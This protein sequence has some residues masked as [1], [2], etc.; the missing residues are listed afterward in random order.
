MIKFCVIN[1]VRNRA[2]I[3]RKLSEH[4][5]KSVCNLYVAVLIITKVSWH[6]NYKHASQ[7]DC[8]NGKSARAS[9]HQYFYLFFCF[10]RYEY[11]VYGQ[12]N[13]SGCLN[14]LETRQNYGVHNN[15]TKAE[16]NKWIWRKNIVWLRFIM[17]FFSSL[18]SCLS[19]APHSYCYSW[20]LCVGYFL[21]LL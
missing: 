12:R 8:N 11:G 1:F 4:M 5:N 18:D 13:F 20:L 10:V 15:N 16:T 2:Q 7:C 21:F 6:T 19:D 9:V 3:K 17:C 14:M